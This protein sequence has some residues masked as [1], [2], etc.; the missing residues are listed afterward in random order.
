MTMELLA[1]VRQSDRQTQTLTEHLRAVAR[2]TGQFAGV[3]GLTEAGEALGLLHDL[4]K[5]SRQFQNYLLSHEGFIAPDTDDFIDARA[6]RGRIDHSTAGAQLIYDSLWNKGPKERA[7]AQVLALCIASHHSGLIDC[8]TPKG[9][10]DFQRR[11]LKNDADT[12]KLEAVTNME[13][14][15]REFADILG[16][17]LVDQIYARLMRLQREGGNETRNVLMFKAGL[18]IRFLLSCLL[19]ADRLDTA[20]F[21]M[22]ENALLRNYGQY[23][24][25]SVLVARLEEKFAAFAAQAQ[26]ARRSPAATVN[27]LRA[28]VA[29]ACLE[30]AAQPQ[31]TYR[32]TV[33]TGGGKTFASLRFAL[34]HA[35]QHG[36]TRVFYIIPYTSIIDQ[37]ADEVRKVLE[38][39][40]EHGRFLDRIVLEHHSNLTPDEE[41]R[42][43]SLLAE[44]WDAPVVFTTQVQF[45]EALFAGRTRSPRRMHQLAN[46]VIILDEAQTI[47]INTFH[48]LNVALRFL[49]EDCGATVVLCTATQPPL[50]KIPAEHRQLVVPAANRIIHNEEE[51]FGEL[52]R[53]KVFQR[54]KVG[55]WSVAEVAELAEDQLRDKGS[56]LIVVNTK[57]SAL[58]LYEAIKTR[59]IPGVRLYHLSTN[60]CPAHRIAILQ[61][62]KERLEHKSP[63]ICVSTQLIEAGVDIDFGA[64]VRYLAGLDSV[65]QAAGRCNRHGARSELGHVWIVNPQEEHLGSLR[66]ILEGRE[67]A[68]WLLDDFAAFPQTFDNDLLGLK[69]MELYYLR[70]YE[71]R[72]AEMD[73]PVPETS[74]VGRADSL[75]ALLSLN[76]LSEQAYQGS[77]GNRRPE[78]AFKQSFHSAA[79]EF[80]VI[81]A[82]TQGV[83]AP[84]RDGA[85]IIDALRS[86]ADLTKQRQLLKQAQRYTI[87]LYAGAF[88]RLVAAGA[89]HEIQEGSG[90][91]YLDERYY[92]PKF[93]A[94]DDIV[95]DMRFY[96]V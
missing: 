26:A 83:I 44:N 87:S 25:W 27:Q 42:R 29:D 80:R 85:A 43:H 21:E 33:P 46:S 35:Q 90:I 70:Y 91:Y 16:R 53:V 79:R 86:S 41:S 31:G 93:G 22:P 1:H 2:L 34:N 73:Y 89:I 9:E 47:P 40:D 3:I 39:R 92:S 11:M 75:F 4:G 48:M 23:P 28:Q 65:A 88:G 58:Y 57:K 71:R 36:L 82:P 66:D 61:E 60:M 10:D 15:R 19:D 77:H 72:K 20:D 17:G 12:H 54:C 56:T 14:I 67:I 38:D 55:G 68:S 49:V 30:A 62:I 7:A 51:L 37:N 24:P 94:S 6:M 84:W 78:I 96:S 52:R 74:C 69:A 13:V 32:L 76:E 45:L 18:L 64:V 81:S 50:D 5:A 8:V 95:S 63:V 59:R